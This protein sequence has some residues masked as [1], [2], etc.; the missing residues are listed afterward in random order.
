MGL[1]TVEKRCHELTLIF[2]GDLNIEFGKNKGFRLAQFL[3]KKYINL[4]RTL[5]TT[6]MVHLLMQYFLN[7]RLLYPLK[8]TYRI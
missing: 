7:S 6:K 4:V 3:K 2:G 5:G 1:T 8:F